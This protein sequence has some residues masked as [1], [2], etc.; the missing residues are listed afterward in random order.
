MG[1]YT[2]FGLVDKREKV[3]SEVSVKYQID[4]IFMSFLGNFITLNGPSVA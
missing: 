4:C 3:E 1:E 2:T